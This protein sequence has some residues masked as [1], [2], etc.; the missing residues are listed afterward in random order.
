LLAVPGLKAVLD[1]ELDNLQD[2]GA[3]KKGDK[4]AWGDRIVG[5]SWVPA[6]PAIPTGT[7]GGNVPICV[8]LGTS[9]L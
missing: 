5:S 7:F 4:D 9:S 6:A 2:F 8:Y 1:V 3:L